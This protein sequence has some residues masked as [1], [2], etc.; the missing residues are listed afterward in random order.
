MSEGEIYMI[1]ETKEKIK[2]LFY[3]NGQYVFEFIN[4]KSKYRYKFFANY[5]PLTEGQIIQ[6]NDL[7]LKSI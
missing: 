7:L 5:N 6:I 4:P 1:K 2:F 3:R